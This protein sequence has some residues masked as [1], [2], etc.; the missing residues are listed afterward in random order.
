[1]AQVTAQQ[2]AD[3]IIAFANGA[4][5]PITNLKLQKLVYYAQGYSLALTGGVLFQDEIEAW[6]HGPVIPGLYHRYKEFRWQPINVDVDVP[7]IPEN[8]KEFL[9][10]II[11]TFLPIDAFKLERMTHKETPWLN[12][13]RGYA[14][15]A[16]CNR[17]IEVNDMKVYFT[18]LMADE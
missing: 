13:R 2:V 10:S 18:A 17:T 11:E 12:A 4:G 1:M 9:D 16:I 3:Y 14:P 5:E 15:T 7:A 8:I 6:V